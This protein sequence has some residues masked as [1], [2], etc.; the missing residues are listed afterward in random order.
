[1]IAMKLTKKESI[2]MMVIFASLSFKG[3]FIG[4]SIG[5]VC[6][7]SLMEHWWCIFAAAI[8]FYVMQRCWK[9]FWQCIWNIKKI[10]E[11]YHD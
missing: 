5:L 8:G 2:I 7:I 11:N 4:F 9:I 1:M 3:V 10:R 6:S